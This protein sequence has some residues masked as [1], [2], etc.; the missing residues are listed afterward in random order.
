MPY[1]SLPLFS[2]GLL[3]CRHC[4]VLV[5]WHGL[6]VQSGFND[7]A[8]LTFPRVSYDLCQHDIV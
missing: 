7:R 6:Y 1:F 4:V 5:A 3:Y 8:H 2:K